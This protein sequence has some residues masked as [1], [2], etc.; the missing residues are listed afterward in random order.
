MA[1]SIDFAVSSDEALE[2]A[3]HYG[4]DGSWWERIKRIR[5]AQEQPYDISIGIQYDEEKLNHLIAQW[6]SKIERPARNATIRMA[7]GAIVPEQQGYRLEVDTLRSMILQSLM[8]NED[9]TI[10]LPVTNLYP[11]VSATDLASMG[12]HE[13]ISTYTTVFDSQNDN[14]VANIKLAATK[15]NGRILYPGKTFSFNDVVGPREKS[16]G[17]KEAIEI[18]DGEFV[19]GVGG[20]ICQLSST[21]YNAVIL[22]NLDIVERYNHSR[23]LPYVPAGRDATV[24]FGTLDFKFVN[25]LA[26][27]LLIV[28]EVH[29]NELMVGIFGQHPMAEKVDIVAVNQEA[30]LP[31]IINQQDDSLYLG[32]T[33]LEK[34]G[35]PG[36]AV[37]IMRVVRLKGQLVKQEILSKDRY[38]AE[39]TILNFGTKIP[40]L[41]KKSNSVF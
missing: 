13:V 27:P 31:Q 12:I 14:R 35:I 1:T 38:L 4:H 21:L 17:F 5:A 40:P 20:G 22:A 24:A 11:E 19:P 3:W 15:V 10:T 33:K 28:A 7:T 39:D 26:E 6:Q 8:K 16:Y 2:A 9:A 23:T 18:A 37:T 41:A 32:E 25:N 29:G 34:Q 30:I 36:V